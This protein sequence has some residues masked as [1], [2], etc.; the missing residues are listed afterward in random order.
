V[1]AQPS[2]I[3]CL[4]DHR[5]PGSRARHGQRPSNLTETQKA[6]ARKLFDLRAEIPAQVDAALAQ[7][8]ADT[9]SARDV[10]DFKEKA[11]ATARAR[12]HKRRSSPRRRYGARP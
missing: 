6:T 1:A 7:H 10:I 4:I 9:R 12:A 2:K 11:L 8:L 5:W 3:V